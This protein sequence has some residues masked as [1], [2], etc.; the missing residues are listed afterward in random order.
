MG[1]Q[2]NVLP[3]AILAEVVVMDP[4]FEMQMPE[5]PFPVTP[6]LDP[7]TDVEFAAHGGLR[8]SIVMR[9]IANPWPG[10]Q[11]NSQPITDPPANVIVHPGNELNDW[12]YNTD[13]TSSANHV[14]AIGTVSTVSSPAPI[15]PPTTF[16]NPDNYIPFQ[17]VNALT[18]M[19]ALNAVE[20]WT[21]FNMNNIR[22]PFHIHVN[23]MYVIRINGQQ[24]E[25]FWA[26]T[27]PLP[28]GGSIT[29]PASFTFRMRFLHYT[30]PYVMHCHMLAHEDM[31]MMQG[32]TVV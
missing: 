5:P 26:D 29:Q 7:I 22:H 23:P 32:V 12:V 2:N 13:D 28:N 21:V 8:R 25:P 3:P 4:P 18:Q 31:G 16:T 20:E 24:V 10:T 14:Y 11:G 27:V 6:F 9:A 1:M 15:Q 19:V 17:S 30:G